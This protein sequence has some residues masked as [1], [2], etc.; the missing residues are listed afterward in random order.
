LNLL[1]D[2]FGA[3]LFAFLWI[4]FFFMSATAGM[5]ILIFAYR[6]LVWALLALSAALQ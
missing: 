4:S 5:T 3:I 6:G 2:I 1:G